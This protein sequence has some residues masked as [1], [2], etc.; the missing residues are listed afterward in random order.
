MDELD[1]VVASLQHRV[2]VADRDLPGR[3][4]DS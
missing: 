3:S 2:V 4:A 1:G